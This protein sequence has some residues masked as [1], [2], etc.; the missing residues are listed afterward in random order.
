MLSSMKRILLLS[1]LLAPNLYPQVN[2]SE[3]FQNTLK[4]V[5]KERVKEDVI[6]WITEQDVIGGIVGRD[7]IA[8]LLDGKDEATLLRGTTNVVSTMLFLG[9]IKM[10][11]Q[12]LVEE[13][14]DVGEQAKSAGWTKEQLIGYS[15]LY[16]YYSERRKYKLYVSPEVL[17]M[18]QEKSRI[19]SFKTTTGRKWTVVVSGRLIRARREDKN[20]SVDVR[21]LEYVDASLWT[22][23]S[24]KE[25]YL[26]NFDTNFN[27]L[28][29]MFQTDKGSREILLTLVDTASGHRSIE[30]LFNLYQQYFD[31]SYT[32]DRIFVSTSS[33]L[34]SVKGDGGN[35]DSTKENGTSNLLVNAFSGMVSTAQYTFVNQEEYKTVVLGTVKDILEMW[36]HQARQNGWKFD[37]AVSLSATAIER[38]QNTN[39]DFT[40][41]DQIRFV[42]Y[43]E[44]T[45]I[46]VY[47][48]G[49]LDP[50]LK[51]TVNKDGEKVFLGGI[52]FGWNA[53]YIAVSAGVECLSVILKNTR[54]AFFFGYEIPVSEL[55]E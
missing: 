25:K 31:S 37:Y 50:L 29:E 39:L 20:L 17:K 40:V 7:L 52:G 54:I 6:S 19:E 41:L 32:T 35:P 33:E 1:V 46:F 53:L 24:N 28:L 18:S 45:R 44:S 30:K 5:A 11:V 22:L 38:N 34:P 8:Q 14:P 27:S 13:N 12:K 15:C 21:I 47:L 51:S 55:L 42:S 36:V 49:L 9:G 26:L 43:Y 3:A 23:I 2:V 48:E 16:Y 10:Y 4:K